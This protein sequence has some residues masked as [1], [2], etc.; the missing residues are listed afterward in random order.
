V[1]VLI[2]FLSK[3]L[4]LSVHYVLRRVFYSMEDTRT[5]FFITVF[6]L[7]VF[8][9]TVLFVPML[10]SDKI[11]IGIAVATS[12]AATAQAV[13]A[14]VLARRKV[15]LPL[16]ARLLVVRHLL[17]FA[18]TLPAAAVG[19]V[20]VSLLGAF[21]EGFAVSGP[22][23]AIV[24]LAAGGS[25]MVAVYAGILLGVRNPEATA[26]VRPVVSRLSRRR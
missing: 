19:L 4:P 7:T 18:A 10:P 17:F 9:T 16:E 25:V 8:V 11:A 20:V 24:T 2:A 3:L 6:Q 23:G 22:F 12:F 26:F 5:P 13:L 14:L 1:W 21:N 15:G